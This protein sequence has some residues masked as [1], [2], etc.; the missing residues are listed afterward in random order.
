MTEDEDSVFR[1]ALEQLPEGVVIV[2]SDDR[3]IFINRRAEEIRRIN[4]KERLGK[5]V[6][7][8]HPEKSH[9]RV[10]RALAHLKSSPGK[11]FQRVVYDHIAARY[12]ENTYT[13]LLYGQEGKVGSLVISRDITERR[14]LEL[15]RADHAK[16]LEET[17][18]RLSN[19]VHNLFISSMTTLTNV[20]EAKDPYTKGHSM[21]IA[22]ASILLA[23]HHLGIG[24]NMREIELSAQLHDIGKVGMRESVLN[25]SGRLEPDEFDHMKSHPVIGFH[26]LEPLEKLRNVAINVRHHHE[27]FDGRGYPNGLKGDAIPLPSR[28]IAILDTYDAMT[29]ARPYRGPLP[30]EK[31]AEEIKRNLGTQFDPDIG[32][33]F[34]D[35]FYTGSIG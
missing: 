2:D 19:E 28:M 34:L 7:A 13:H 17:V 9:E 22:E 18:D 1:S 21:R 30:K 27:R 10:R 11:P 15:E 16:M 35:L 24:S 14:K 23:E 31:A 26:I 12:Y 20:L 29:T 25:K 6:I 3:I 4:A 8:C 32:K 5:S 33:T